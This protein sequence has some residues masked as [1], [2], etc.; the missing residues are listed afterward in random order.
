MK[1]ILEKVE[2]L[3]KKLSEEKLG[4]LKKNDG[5]KEITYKGG[6]VDLKIE[7]DDEFV[8]SILKKK[9]PSIFK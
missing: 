9:F 1:V 6:S 3:I 5:I 4:E 7:C 8:L 2:E